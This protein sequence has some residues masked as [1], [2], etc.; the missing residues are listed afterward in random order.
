MRPYVTPGA[1]VWIEIPTKAREGSCNTVTPGAGVWI[2]IPNI[3]LLGGFLF[4]TPGAGVW[5][6]IFNM[7]VFLLDILSLPVRE[8]G[9]KYLGC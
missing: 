9:L 4:V 2:E 3:T 1:G 5:I 7:M 8:C 6:E